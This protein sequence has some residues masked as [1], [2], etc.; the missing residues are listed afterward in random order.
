MIDHPIYKI[1]S[2]NPLF[3]G[4]EQ[5]W[6]C[7]ESDDLHRLLKGMA[8]HVMSSPHCALSCQAGKILDHY[9]SPASIPWDL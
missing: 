9:A 6:R 4:V 2:E 7:L 8:F 5:D 3:V 1:T